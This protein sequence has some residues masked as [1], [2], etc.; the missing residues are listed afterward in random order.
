MGTIETVSFSISPNADFNRRPTRCGNGRARSTVFLSVRPK[1]LFGGKNND[2]G[3]RKNR[4]TDDKDDTLRTLPNGRWVGLTVVLKYNRVPDV[5][6]FRTGHRK[7]LL[8]WEKKI[9]IY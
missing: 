5:Y 7:T 3:T 4:P 8:S 6:V 1:K 9:Y 2:V